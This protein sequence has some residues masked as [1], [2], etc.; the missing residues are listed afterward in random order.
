MINEIDKLN[1][2]IKIQSWIRMLLAK[3]KL[4][5]PNSYYQSKI[6][7]RNRL[8]YKTGKSNECEIYQISLI[9]KITKMKLLK[10]H[11]RINMETKKIE[12]KLYPMRN[13]NGFE[14]TE[15]FDG[16][17]EYNNNKLLYNLKFVCDKGGSQT[18]T[19]RE[20]YLFI[21]Y[22][23]KVLKN[24][25]HSLFI[26]INILDGDTSNTAMNKFNYLLDKSDNRKYSKFIFVGDMH[27]FQNH[28]SSSI[29]ILSNR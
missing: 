25:A 2:I 16:I 6:W 27:Q 12:T 4:L 24:N 3:A 23:I 1:A 22:Q 28:W 14:Y 15:N 26:F 7:R 20:V 13:K 29:S 19:L 21:K 5:I 17:Q 18:R 9:E 10:C 11:E 8:W